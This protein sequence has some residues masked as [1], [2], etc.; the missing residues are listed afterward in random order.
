MRNRTGNGSLFSL[1]LVIALAMAFGGFG[2]RVNA[3]CETKIV[4]SD[5]AE[6]DGF[7][8]SVSV[9]GD[10]MVIGAQEL[11][12]YNRGSAYVFRYDGFDW[13]E[14]AKLQASDGNE[15]D[16]FGCSVSIDGDVIVVGAYGDDNNGSVSGSAY[17]YRF[18]GLEWTEEAKLLASDGGAYDW[19]GWS[20]STDGDAIVIGAQF[21]D[22]NGD[23]S[24]SAYVYRHSGSEWVEED[25]LLASDGDS[26][27]LFGVSVSIAGDAISVGA[28]SYDTGSAYVYR[29]DGFGWTEEAKLLA[30]DGDWGDSFGWSVSINSDAIVVGARWD[31]D[32]G[33]LSGSAYVFRYD[34][35]GWTEEAKLLPSYGSSSDQF[36]HSVSIDSDV[37]A[38]G[39]PGDNYNGGLSGSAYVFRYDGSG[40]AEDTK[41]L[42]S[43][44]DDMDWFSFSVSI[45]ADAVATGVVFDDDNGDGS[46]SAY[47]YDLSC[48]PPLTVSPNP[49]IAGQD[50]T[51]TSRNLNPY[52][53]TY[54]AY[55]LGGLGSTYIPQLNVML[56]LRQP[57]QAG[58]TIISD[59]NGVAEWVLFVPNAGIGR[60]VWF[61]ACQYEVTTNVIATHIE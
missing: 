33:S 24:G 7:G 50:A 9:S 3:Q 57:K 32:N 11:H 10:V 29:Y 15:F 35:F 26:N 56:D 5:G 60:D 43:D 18:D 58:N 55:S 41:L 38:I 21:D 22:D 23:A 19:F 28:A 36:G 34:G 2:Q 44:G 42:A 8:R 13:I 40:W 14:E 16:G 45:D 17:V 39:A 12:T 48:E 30:S 20:V 1:T 31:G 54:L 61:Q 49:L 51:F 47:V 25:K 46:G 37:V 6:Y 4:A 27:D 59:S 52:T 53:Q